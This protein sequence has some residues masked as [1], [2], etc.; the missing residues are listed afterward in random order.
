MAHAERLSQEQAEL[1]RG[2]LPRVHLAAL[3]RLERVLEEKEEFERK[4]GLQR[5]ALEKHESEKELEELCRIASELPALWQH[6]AMSHQE[7]KEILRCLI[8]HIVVTAEKERLDATIV[9]KSGAQSPV[10]V[11]R[12][13]SRHHLIRELHGQQLTVAQ[14]T[15]HLA[16]GNTSTGQS[17]NH[18]EGA[19]RIALQ[20]MGLKAAKFS[21]SRVMVR[22]KAAELH[23]QGNSV[24]W[25]AQYFN[26]QGV[27]SPSGKSWTH[28]MVEN[29]LRAFR[30]QARDQ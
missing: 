22:R 18:S 24:R 23:A 3:E 15:A 27:E 6:E 26:T 9:W 8:D 20:K 11:W 10:F 1:S 29:M 12:P 25:I 5:M 21:A 7:R 14:I 2:K 17:V 19:I 30:R 28:Y 4:T 16:A 13:R